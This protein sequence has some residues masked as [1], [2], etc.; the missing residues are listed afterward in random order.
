MECFGP[1][2]RQKF[3]ATPLTVAVE[4]TSAARLTCV[5]YIW[6]R[7]SDGSWSCYNHWGSLGCCDC[8]GCRFGF[9]SRAIDYNTE[10]QMNVVGGCD[11]QIIVCSERIIPVRLTV[12]FT[13]VLR[14]PLDEFVLGVNYQRTHQLC[15][16]APTCKKNS[17]RTTVNVE[18]SSYFLFLSFR[19][20]DST[21]DLINMGPILH[22]C[23][24]GTF[25]VHF[26]LL[27]GVL[28]ITLASGNEGTLNLCGLVQP[29]SLN[30]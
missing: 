6:N 5:C 23:G 27:R 17:L 4:M 13:A 26:L 1:P 14:D 16:P 28:K 22:K 29:N 11:R 30:T 25:L 3:P 21:L 15:V 7:L 24:S 10:L 12:W 8:W 18:H 9:V 19:A 20:T 2:P